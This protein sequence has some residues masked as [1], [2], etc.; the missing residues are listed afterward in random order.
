MTATIRIA[1]AIILDDAGRTLLVRKQGT[2]AFMQ[3][4]GKIEGGEAPLDALRRELHEEL[5]LTLPASGVDPVGRF[6]A[7]AANEPG[8]LVVAEIFRLQLDQTD[9]HPAAEI[10]EAIWIDPAAPPAIT[11]APLTRDQ[12]LPLAARLI[13]A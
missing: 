1:A 13:Q 8:H 10:A 7:P 9:L 3:A 2:Q 12:I 4:G 5:G 6:E 11:L